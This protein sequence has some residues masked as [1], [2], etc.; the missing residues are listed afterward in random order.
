MESAVSDLKSKSCLIYDNGLFVELAPRLAR[1]FGKVWYAMPWKNAYPRAAPAI[2]GDGL[3]G[4]ERVL[5]FWEYVPQADIVMF[6]DIYDADMQK[7]V[8]DTFGKPVWGSRGAEALELDRWG[9]RRLQKDL[10]IAAPGTKFITGIDN[11]AA[12]LEKTHDKWV[13]ISTFRGDGETWHHQSWHTSQIYLQHFK[14]RVGA[15]ADHYEFMVENSVEGIEVGYDG[16][17]VHGSFPESAYY[18][19]E[20]KDCGYLGVFKSYQEHPE[21]IRFINSKLAG[22]L[23]KEKA[24]GFC[25]FEFRMGSQRVPYLIDPCLRAGS[26]PIE[27]TMEGYDNLGEII[28]AGAHGEMVEAEPLGQF[29]AMAM[30]HCSFALHNWVPIDCPAEIRRWLKLRNAAVL[31]GKLYHVPVGG[32]MPEIGA[33]VAAADSQQKAINLV[34]ER[35]E[36]VSGYLLEIHVEALDKAEEEIEKAASFGVEF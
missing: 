19:F 24:V 7:V 22:I 35:A 28:W 14:N 21:P 20:I 16:W 34:R 11:L 17:T 26:P 2:V 29:T 3:E 9:T 10:G 27:S 32:E 31:D 30:I 1:D 5:N 18:G 36:Q 23:K 25:S 8:A 12:Y 6:P 13:K 4:V 15:L 33:V